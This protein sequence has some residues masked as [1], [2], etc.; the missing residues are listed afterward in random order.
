MDIVHQ[1]II[2]VILHCASTDYGLSKY[3]RMKEGIVE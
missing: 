3:F 1:G 2:P